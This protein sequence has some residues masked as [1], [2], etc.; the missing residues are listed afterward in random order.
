MQTMLFVA[1][2]LAVVTGLAHSVF[3]ERLIFRHLR[4][5][6]VVP[7]AAAPPLRERHIRI[8]WATW[9]VATLF[10]WAFGAVLLQLAFADDGA[11]LRTIVVNAIVLSHLG[12][13]ALVLVGTRGR[14]PGWIALLA[15]AMLVRFA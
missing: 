14:H 4:G 13:S 10:G 6:G 15:V 5:S 8:L 2:V 1:G 11:S 7:A 12:G 3:G 9:H